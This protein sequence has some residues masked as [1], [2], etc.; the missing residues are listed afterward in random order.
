MSINTT[1]VAYVLFGLFNC[2]T[3]LVRGKCRKEK[4]KNDEGRY[5]PSERTSAVAL[6]SLKVGISTTAPLDGLRASR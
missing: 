5:M 2:F 3:L 4:R 1:L 6:K